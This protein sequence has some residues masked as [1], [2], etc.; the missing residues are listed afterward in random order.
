M[1]A[2]ASEGRE[3]SGGIIAPAFVRFPPEAR[4]RPPLLSAYRFPRLLPLLEALAPESLAGGTGGGAGGGAAGRNAGGAGGGGA[5]AGGDGGGG[6]LFVEVARLQNP[7]AN[8][9]RLTLRTL[10]EQHVEGYLPS[11]GRALQDQP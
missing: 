4:A 1:R 8:A 2:P 7:P 3:K 6:G 10:Q 5:A 11:S 9:W